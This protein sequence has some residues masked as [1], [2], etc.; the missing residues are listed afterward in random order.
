VTNQEFVTDAVVRPP[1]AREEFSF[2]PVAEVD[3][4]GETTS[5]LIFRFGGG[6]VFPG[7][8]W[9]MAGDNVSADVVAVN[10]NLVVQ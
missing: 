2:A 6:A 9:V 1:A 7:D 8:E 5:P 10:E 4:S 3:A